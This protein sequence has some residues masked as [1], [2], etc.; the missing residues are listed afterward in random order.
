V[1]VGFSDADAILAKQLS[2]RCILGTDMAK[3][4][5][6]LEAFREKLSE[7]LIDFDQHCDSSSNMENGLNSSHSSASS[8]NTLE[9]LSDRTST[10]AQLADIFARDEEARAMTMVILLKMCDISTEIRPTPVSQPWLNCLVTE[11]A[12]QVGLEQHSGL[13]VSPLMDSSNIARCQ[14]SFLIFAM[15]P[16]AESIV[17]IIPGIKSSFLTPA[18]QQLAYYTKLSIEEKNAEEENVV[19]ARVRVSVSEAVTPDTEMETGDSPVCEVVAYASTPQNNAVAIGDCE[20]PY[21]IVDDKVCGNV[22]NPIIGNAPV[23][24]PLLSTP[25][26]VQFSTC[27]HDRAPGETM[28]LSSA[29][30][31]EF[32]TGSQA[33]LR[34]TRRSL[35]ELPWARTLH[36]DYADSENWFLDSSSPWL[37]H[38]LCL[39]SPIELENEE[40]AATASV[41]SQ[42]VFR[43]QPARSTISARSLTPPSTS[44]TRRPPWWRSSTTAAPS[45]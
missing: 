38:S 18:Q 41:P 33:P 15:I 39:S 44:M 7:H 32:H 42:R 11:L 1:F 37:R 29:G 6:I 43:V 45:F 30:V 23:P 26:S 34:P 13:P 14:Y 24:R 9:L 40:G 10:F 20:Q 27:V 19:K 5:D 36:Q 31:A 21:S 35:G 25:L 3:H 17:S 16:L 2:L 28:V 8:I 4:S 22:D 12:A